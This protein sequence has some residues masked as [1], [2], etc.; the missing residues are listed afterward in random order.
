MHLSHSC[1]SVPLSL[2]HMYVYVCDLALFEL[3]EVLVPFH[4]VQQG[5]SLEIAAMNIVPDCELRV[6]VT[7][8]RR[9]APSLSNHQDV[10]RTSVTVTVAFP[11]SMIDPRFRN[12]QR[13]FILFF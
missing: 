3:P 6:R 4:G 10:M 9:Y 2:I 1:L 8:A 13:N 11:P 5:M 7:M 12:V